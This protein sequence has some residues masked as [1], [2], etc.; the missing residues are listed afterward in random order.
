MNLFLYCF[1]FPVFSPDCRWLSSSISHKVF[2]DQ[3]SEKNHKSHNGILHGL[4]K[5]CA[6]AMFAYFF[7]QVL[8]F[9]HGKRWEYLGTPMGNWYLTE[10][11]GFV[12]LPMILYF[13][14]YRK[15]KIVLIKIAS[16]IAMLGIIVN[17][18]N[19]TVIGFKWYA[20]VQYIPSWMEIVVTLAVIFTEI[21]IFRWVVTRMPVLRDSPTWAKDSH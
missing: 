15:Q 18:L 17:R 5:I 13:I 7:L 20:D 14:S 16:V 2:S 1:L 6:V 8:V 19:V 10:M 12:L 11:L 3:I 4:S 21:W 9:I